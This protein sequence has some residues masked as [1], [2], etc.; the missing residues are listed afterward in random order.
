MDKIERLKTYNICRGDYIV[1]S[2][3]PDNFELYRKINELID[4]IDELEKRIEK[5]EGDKR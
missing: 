5:L 2:E 4:Y 3:A 1:G